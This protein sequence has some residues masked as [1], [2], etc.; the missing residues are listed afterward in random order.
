MFRQ[1]TCCLP[2]IG[3]FR[4]KYTP[5]RYDVTNK[6][7][8]PPGESITFDE[9]LT[10]DGSLTEWIA[11]KEHLVTSIAQIKK[12]KY[13]EELKAFLKKGQVFE[14]PG[15]GKLKADAV[16]R[17]LFEQAPPVLTRDI[18]HVTPVI[19]PDAAHKVTVGTREM[20]NNQVV[21][22]LTAAADQ[23]QISTTPPTTEYPEYHGYEEEIPS[24]LRWLWIAVPILSV[25]TAVLVW[26][27]V[28]KKEKPG[29]P[30]ANNART[31][32]V[33]TDTPATQQAQAQ[34][35]TDSAATTAIP[36]S[37]SELEYD[38]IISTH[39]KRKAGEKMFKDR[40]SW[41]QK[42]VVIRYNT[43]STIVKLGI[44]FRT[45]AADTTANK[46]AVLEKYKV[47]KVFLELRNN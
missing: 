3:V 37:L 8:E 25:L 19:R 47:G 12:D 27:T 36:D 46:Q 40:L 14:V 35:I 1:Q 10:D 5:A 4:L 45:P 28:S 11:Q 7:I 43:D 38:V 21:D 24:P 17:L 33:V 16:G 31:T 18:L 32:A 29:T 6:T 26:Y 23:H 13:L 42:E 41:G 20:V 39:T 34:P 9:T 44:P 22:H 2:Q 15:I 30:P